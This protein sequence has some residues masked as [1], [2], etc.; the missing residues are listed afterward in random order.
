[1]AFLASFSLVGTRLK[2]GLLG[3]TNRF[4]W[5]LSLLNPG[6]ERGVSYCQRGSLKVACIISR[7][8]PHGSM[9][10]VS[11]NQLVVVNPRTFN[12]ANIRLH[13]E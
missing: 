6:I 11:W 8:K 2:A 5:N 4:V 7:F 3:E 12:V 10:T 1:M 9:R 13:N